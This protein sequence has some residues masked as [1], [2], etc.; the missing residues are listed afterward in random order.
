VDCTILQNG[1]V[2]PHIETQFI[3]VASLVPHT[4]HHST[5]VKIGEDTITESR[6]FSLTSYVWVFVARHFTNQKQHGVAMLVEQ[7]SSLRVEL[8]QQLTKSLTDITDNKKTVC[9]LRS[10][11]SGKR[12]LVIVVLIKKSLAMKKTR[13]GLVGRINTIEMQIEAL[14]SSDFNRTML[15]TMQST[16]DVMRKMGLDKGLSQADSTISE[17]E[18]NM[19]MACDMNTA[20]SSSNSDYLND[21]E[22]D[23]ELDELMDTVQQKN[24]S[25]PVGTKTINVELP[26]FTSPTVS[27]EV[28]EPIITESVELVSSMQVSDDLDPVR[29]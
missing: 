25:V 2:L 22:L 10:K 18:E 26:A 16:A 4:Y 23:A 3:Y 5:M 21:D 11:G 14:E 29:V 15:K 12:D 19:Q 24:T 20:L 8:K 9:S 27:Q 17:L 13:D 6:C 7:L 28:S 1:P